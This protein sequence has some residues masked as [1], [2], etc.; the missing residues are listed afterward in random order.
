MV[1]ELD[2]VL[3]SKQ[4]PTHSSH[5][6][7]SVLF[8]NRIESHPHNYDDHHYDNDQAESELRKA[9]EEFDKQVEL[10]TEICNKIIKSNEQHVKYLSKFVEAQAEYYQHADKHLDDLLNNR[11]EESRN[12]STG[13][14]TFA[15]L[16]ENQP[17]E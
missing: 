9:Q 15:A 14:A 4:T 10:V 7:S 3:C 17:E 1:K 11:T 5:H 2:E 6:S 8:T 12:N 13:F 16:S